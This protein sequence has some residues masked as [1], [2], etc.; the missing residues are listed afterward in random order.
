MR[1]LESKKTF[2]SKLSISAEEDNTCTATEIQA[3]LL[4]T[5][6]KKVKR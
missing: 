3:T 5:L 4:L 1:L 6:Q 2:L